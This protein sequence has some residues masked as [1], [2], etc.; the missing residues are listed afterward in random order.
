MFVYTSGSLENIFNTGSFYEKSSAFV[1]SPCV[2]TIKQSNR[3]FPVCKVTEL[4]NQG[5][6]LKLCDQ[7]HEC[8]IAST[9]EN[10]IKDWI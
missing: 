3:M 2:S 9:E 1:T 7:T 4:N 5:K 10:K 8:F 6:I